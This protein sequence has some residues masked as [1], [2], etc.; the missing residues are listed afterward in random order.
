LAAASRGSASFV[1]PT[2]SGP[3][4]AAEPLEIYDLSGRRVTSLVP[5]VAA[6]AVTWRWDGRDATG[7]PAGAGVYFAR[8]R[9]GT[10]SLRVTRV[11]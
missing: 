11:R 9:T 1:L 8:T 4:G 2:A 7:T 10:A 6:G 5:T 3:G